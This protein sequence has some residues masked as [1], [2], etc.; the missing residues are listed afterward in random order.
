MTADI[1]VG[2]EMIKFLGTPGIL[3][4]R[5]EL[6]SYGACRELSPVELST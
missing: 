1:P 6:E 2:T 3:E 4:G 5:L